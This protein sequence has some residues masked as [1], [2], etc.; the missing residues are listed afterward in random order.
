MNEY[1]KML[2]GPKGWEDLS[3]M[4]TVLDA[5]EEYKA[6]ADGYRMLNEPETDEQSSRKSGKTKDE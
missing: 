6:R 3:D 4:V 5:D 1:P 2:Y